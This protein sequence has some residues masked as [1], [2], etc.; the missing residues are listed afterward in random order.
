MVDLNFSHRR[1]PRQFRF[2]SMWVEHFEYN[3][4]VKDG[5]FL[6]AEE[7]DLDKVWEVYARL[8]SCKRRLSLWSSGAFPNNNKEIDRLIMRDLSFIKQGRM[9]ANM[10]AEVD[11]IKC[12]VQKFWGLE[13]NFRARDL[14]LVG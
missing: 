12:E 9:T 8:S 14:V 3:S 2:E 10:A 1:T 6:D 11:R 4:V 7:E 5:W 13:E